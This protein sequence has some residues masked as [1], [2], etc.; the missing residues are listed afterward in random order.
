[1]FRLLLFQ[2]PFATDIYGLIVPNFG[3]GFAI[4]KS[5]HCNVLDSSCSLADSPLTRLCHR[6]GGL[7]YDAYYG[8]PGGPAA[9]LCLWK[10]VRHR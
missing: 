4:G 8:L 1:M 7:L 5:D 3:V 10:R 9:R 6:H 2:V